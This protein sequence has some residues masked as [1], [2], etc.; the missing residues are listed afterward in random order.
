MLLQQGSRIS[1]ASHF[2]YF[3]ICAGRVV[4]SYRQVNIRLCLIK[5]LFL[6]YLAWSNNN[7]HFKF[8]VQ[9]SETPLTW[10]LWNCKLVSIFSMD[11]KS[12]FWRTT[13]ISSLRRQNNI[14]SCYNVIY[15]PLWPTSHTVLWLSQ[16]I[17]M[18]IWRRRA[19]YRYA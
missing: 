2:P 19:L 18:L 14:T 15:G 1:N 17:E 4:G 13:S 10:F 3:Y 8:I 6:K 7:N 9:F 5:E 12:W 11:L 16:Q